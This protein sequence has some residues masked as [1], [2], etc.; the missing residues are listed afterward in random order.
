MALLR[1]YSIEEV[2]DLLRVSPRTVRR[3]IK[4]GQ[5]RAHRFGRTMRIACE[6]LQDFIARH[7]IRGDGD[8]RPDLSRPV[9]ALKIVGKTPNK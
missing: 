9:S 7:E 3:W 6:D 4:A 8:R 2:A 1:F 5:L